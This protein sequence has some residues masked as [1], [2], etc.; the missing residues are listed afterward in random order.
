[1]K[2]VFFALLV[3]GCLSIDSSDPWDFSNVSSCESDGTGFDT[4]TG[5]F[6]HNKALWDSQNV[7]T[8]TYRW[9]QEDS[10]NNYM[11]MKWENI[12]FDIA[13]EQAD[14][15]QNGWENWGAWVCFPVASWTTPIAP[16]TKGI[17]VHGERNSTDDDFEWSNT[18]AS[19]VDYEGGNEW[20]FALNDDSGNIDVTLMR[21]TLRTKSASIELRMKTSDWDTTWE[22]MDNLFCM[23]DITD[24]DRW[25]NNM[26]LSTYKYIYELE[27]PQSSLAVEWRLPYQ[28]PAEDWIDLCRLITKAGAGETL[29]VS[30]IT[31]TT[32]IVS[33]F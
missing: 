26:D 22:D 2:I 16:G 30:M 14:I 3:L 18:F 23:F 17:V 25:S 13:D 33:L 4:A 10:N 24:D 5:C 19:W 9:F 20:P 12:F 15:N 1:M 31:L 7:K 21:D 27:P 28:E 11:R 29:A 8:A 32:L 6:A